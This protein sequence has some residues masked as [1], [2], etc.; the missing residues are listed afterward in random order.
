MPI[1]SLAKRCS[2]PYFPIFLINFFY[3]I[4]YFPIVFSILFVI[5]YFE[6]L[7]CRFCQLYRWNWILFWERD[8]LGWRMVYLR[9]CIAE[10]WFCLRRLILLEL[11]QRRC[12]LSVLF[13]QPLALRILGQQDLCLLNHQLSWTTP[14]A[15]TAC[16]SSVEY[17]AWPQ[18]F[19]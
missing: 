7:L 6:L 3:F 9:C 12:R 8:D 11:V 18:P 17:T 5:F 13:L 4:F 2:S 15:W 1:F 16:S 10:S 14:D 19:T